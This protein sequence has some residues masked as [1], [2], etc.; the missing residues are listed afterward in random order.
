MKVL[1]FYNHTPK[2][3]I[4]LTSCRSISRRACELLESHQ[5]CMKENHRGDTGDDGVCVARYSTEWSNNSQI[6]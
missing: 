4:K 6:R 3:F 5:S 2:K 1:K